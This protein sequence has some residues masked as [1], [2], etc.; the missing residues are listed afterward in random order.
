MTRDPATGSIAPVLSGSDREA[1]FHE[2][3]LPGTCLTEE[4]VRMANVRYAFAVE[5]AAGKRVLE[6]GCGP[7]LGLAVLSRCAE[8]VV[9][10]DIVPDSLALA[11]RRCGS[12][13][14]LAVMDGGWLPFRDGCFDVVILFEVIY[15][16]ASPD[17]VLL[18]CRRILAPGG[19]VLLCMPNPDH[20]TF[21]PSPCG[22]SYLTTCQLR[23]L[24]ERHEFAPS[25]WGGFPLAGNA[26]VQKS[27]TRLRRIVARKLDTI[28]GGPTLK[29]F[30]HSTFLGKNIPLPE[31]LD[32][33]SED[34]VLI[35][36]AV[37]VLDRGHRVLFA[38]GLRT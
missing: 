35:P 2:T 37:N 10:G 24:L 15:Y 33:E 19:R 17:A 34:R 14:G 6:I 9:G 5:H 25:L 32:L 26:A 23:Q 21:N 7:G 27:V 4:Q 3:E 38:L 30:A 36:L 13:V 8:R 11:R 28:P 20:P 18:E 12:G 1:L 22:R 29:R 31:A 16:F